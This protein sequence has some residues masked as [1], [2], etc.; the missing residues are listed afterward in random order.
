MTDADRFAGEMEPSVR[1]GKAQA[2]VQLQIIAR[3]EEGE[4][5]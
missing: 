5:T 4:S 2:L 1:G 3:P